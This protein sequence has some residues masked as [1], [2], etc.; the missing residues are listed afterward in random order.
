MG[1]LSQVPVLEVFP[2]LLSTPVVAV[3][4]RRSGAKAGVRYCTSTDHGSPSRLQNHVWGQ[5]DSA[6]AVM[7]FLGSITSSWK[8]ES[9]GKRQAGKPESRRA[10]HLKAH[11]CKYRFPLSM[12]SGPR[13]W[14]PSAWSLV[15]VQR[16]ALPGSPWGSKRTCPTDNTRRA[17]SASRAS[18]IP[19]PRVRVIRL[20]LQSGRRWGQLGPTAVRHLQLQCLEGM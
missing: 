1:H 19:D 6:P 15:L 5:I 4:V 17:I 8:K 9:L 18:L 11:A 3:L 13:R 12:S 20:T 2:I 16:K 10:I 7:E 14:V